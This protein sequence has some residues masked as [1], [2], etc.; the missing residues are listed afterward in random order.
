MNEIQIY[1]PGILLA[2]GAFLVGIASPGPNVMA[3]MGTS[4][5]VGRPQGLALAMGIAV[6]SLSWALLTALGLSAVLTQY[7]YT[8][9]FIKLFGAAYLL[10]LA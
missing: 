5:S 2:Y 7:A 10:F 3:V 8:L 4:M 9:F 1:L 6:G